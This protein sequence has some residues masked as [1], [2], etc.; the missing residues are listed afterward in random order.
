MQQP[1]QQKCKYDLQRT[2][3]AYLLALAY[4]ALAGH[5]PPLSNVCSSSM[6][7]I[8]THCASGQLCNSNGEAASGYASGMC[9]LLRESGK[10]CLCEKATLKLSHL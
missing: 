5:N 3:T 10:G 9:M 1:H 2:S 6:T 7:D 4:H 8:S